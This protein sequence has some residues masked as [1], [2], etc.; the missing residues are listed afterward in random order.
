VTKLIVRRG[1]SATYQVFLRVFADSRRLEV[2]E[3]RRSRDRRHQHESAPVDRRT[4]ERRGPP[5]RT[6]D[7]ADFIAVEPPEE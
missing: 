7:L 5:P 4:G 3:D 2:I 1:L 6:W